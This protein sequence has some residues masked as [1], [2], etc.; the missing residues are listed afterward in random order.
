MNLFQI[1]SDIHIEKMYP[2]KIKI[3]TIIKPS[4]PNLILAG[5]VGRYSFIKEYYERFLTDLCLLFEK[6]Y[7]VAGNH[8]YFS[9]QKTINEIKVDLMYLKN[10]ISNLVIL[11]DRGVDIQGT[12]IRLYGTTLW[13]KIPDHYIGTRPILSEHFKEV[14]TVWFNLQHYT[15]LYMLEKDVYENIGKKKMII[16]SHYPPL[17]VGVLKNENLKNPQRFYYSNNL[18]Y[19]LGNEKIH[20]WISG[21]TH[22]NCDFFEKGTRIVSNQYKGDGY[23]LDKVITVE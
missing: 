23:I 20:T 16:I 7:F 10:K 17:T 11:D 19:I 5:D 22:N 18:K 13:S 21:H 8:E 2:Q 12:D 9:K 15:S 3:E 1:A 6:V 4:C 14:N